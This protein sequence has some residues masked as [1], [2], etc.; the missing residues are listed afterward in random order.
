[1]SLADLRKKGWCCHVPPLARSQK[2]A[3]GV[4]VQVSEG[5]APSRRRHGIWW[6]SLQRSKIMH[7]FGKNNVILGL[8]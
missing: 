2:F 7:S 6:R 3:M 5:S 4:C 8:F 1:M